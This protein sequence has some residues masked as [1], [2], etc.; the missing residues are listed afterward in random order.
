MTAKQ[1]QRLREKAGIT[2][3]QL[4]RKLGVTVSTVYRWE[5]GKASPRRT[6][7]KA[8]MRIVQ[9]GA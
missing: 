8:M 4:A 5:S 2:Q 1:I 7:A 9:N 6:F 3:E